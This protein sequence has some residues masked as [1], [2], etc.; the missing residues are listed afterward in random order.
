[1]DLP[2]PP[3]LLAA[4]GAVL[5]LG[6]LGAIALA[7]GLFPPLPR[8][9][10]GVEDLSGEAERVRIPLSHADALDAYVLGG[11]RPAVIV[12]F[13]G[14]ARTHTRSWRYA[15]FLRCLGVHI[16]CFDFR[17]SRSTR[18]KPTAL[19]GTEREDAAAVLDWVVGEPRFAGCRIGFH[20]ESL[21]GSV[22]LDLAARRPEVAAVVADA[23]FA[24]AGLALE[25]SC[26]GMVHL[27]R[28]PSASI[29]RAVTR[30]VTGY[31]PGVFAPV[32]SVHGLSG[33]PVFFIHGA[34][35]PRIS[36]NQSRE[37][38]RAAGAKDPLWIVPGAKH[39]EAWRVARGRYEA[40]VTAFFAHTLLGDG[41]GIPVGPW[42]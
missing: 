32:D 9:L 4:L 40:S 42:D 27:P 37:L 36:P 31:D 10:G 26:A 14:F 33:R 34:R 29:L 20:G 23:A 39:N 17:S 28:Q 21:G 5:G 15:A 11:T 7:A 12:L 3:S 16:V 41:E 6:L 19:G 30:A 22:A 38:W 35:D 24:V 18:R 2:I 25:D 8:D 1:M 13:H